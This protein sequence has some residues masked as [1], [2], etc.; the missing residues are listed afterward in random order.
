MVGQW[1]SRDNR[2]L[3]WARA[4]FGLSAATV[5]LAWKKTVTTLPRGDFPNPRP[6]VATYNFGWNGIVAATGEFKFDRA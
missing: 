6:F 3:A 1:P 4:W 2:D 5:P